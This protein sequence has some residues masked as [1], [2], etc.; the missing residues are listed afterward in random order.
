[1]LVEEGGQVLEAHIL[2]SLVPSIEHLIMIGDPLQLRPTVNNFCERS[3]SELVLTD[4]FSI[5]NGP[6][7]GKANLSVRS[8]AHGTAIFLGPRYVTAQRSEAN[9]PRYFRAYQVLTIPRSICPPTEIPQEY[10]VQRPPRQ[11]AC[12]ALPTCSRYCA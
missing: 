9:A 11:R 3:Q 2:G 10:A 5:F 6:S 1:M 4:L 8:I 7:Y 12:H